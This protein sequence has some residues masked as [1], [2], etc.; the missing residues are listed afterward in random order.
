[1]A[2]Y[3]VWRNWGG[4]ED[5]RYAA[6]RE[7]H[8]RAF[9]WVSL[10]T[11]FGLQG[12][13]MWVVSAPLQVAVISP[14]PSTLTI[15]DGIGLSLWIVGFLFETIGDQQLASFKADPAKR[16]KVMDTGLWAWTRH[17]NYFGEAVLWWGYFFIALSTPAGLLTVFSPILMT[18][19]LLKISGVALLEKALVD[20]RP[21]YREYVENTSAFF[22]WPPKRGA[23][24]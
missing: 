1:L 2:A 10:F 4:G 6:M 11:V 13:L 5:Y 17:P 3:I 12:V 20:R 16:G 24:D 22:P 15:W 8:G 7:H 19:L 18:Y 14:N 21:G 23:S 9:V